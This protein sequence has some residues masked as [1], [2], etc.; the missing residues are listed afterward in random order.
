[1]YTKTTGPS[2]LIL[3]PPPAY[4]PHNSHQRSVEDGLDVQDVGDVPRELGEA[5]QRRGV[6]ARERRHLVRQPALLHTEGDPL[7]QRV[8]ERLG[9]TGGNGESPRGESTAAECVTQ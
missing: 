3:P 4:Q 5:S 9:K 8:E 7:L 1:M 6:R 2:S